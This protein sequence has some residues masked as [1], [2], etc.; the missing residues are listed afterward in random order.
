[1]EVDSID[2]IC[3]TLPI[4]CHGK[5]VND[6]LCFADSSQDQHQS[7]LPHGREDLFVRAAVR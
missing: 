3:R 7:T 1:M 2:E 6:V 5:L 4:A